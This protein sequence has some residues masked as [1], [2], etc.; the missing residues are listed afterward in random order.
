M[1]TPTPIPARPARTNAGL[2]RAIRYL[3][4]HPL[5][6]LMPY[7]FLLIATLSQ[8][9]IPSMVRNVI[10]AIT[11]GVAANLLVPRLDVIPPSLLPTVFSA[12]GR[13]K[14]QLIADQANAEQMLLRAGA[15][16]L[17]L[18]ALRSVF[19]FLQAYTKVIK[20]F[21]REQ[22]EQ[23]KFTLTNFERRCML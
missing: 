4:N 23:A 11:R 22:S 8:L 6:S 19:A 1:L 2:G 17:V 21:T 9:L 14:E 16:I 20:A 18:A 10:D 3:W 7:G 12:L 15:A 5:I 13:T